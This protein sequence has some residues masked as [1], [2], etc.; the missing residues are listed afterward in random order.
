MKQYS[1]VYEQTLID[2]HFGII[3]KYLHFKWITIFFTHFDG[4]HLINT[5]SAG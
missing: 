4:I 2:V 3:E 5:T 1:F